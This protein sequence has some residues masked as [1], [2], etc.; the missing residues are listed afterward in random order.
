V[1]YDM[2]CK[3]LAPSN[4]HQFQVNGHILAIFGLRLFVI[5][6]QYM[7]SILLHLTPRMYAP[8]KI[9]MVILII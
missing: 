6:V 4:V 9:Y 1:V 7:F 5:V 8:R 2:S 3:P